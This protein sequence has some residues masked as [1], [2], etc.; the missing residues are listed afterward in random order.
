MSVERL[1]PTPGL[2]AMVIRRAARIPGFENALRSDK[3]DKSVYVNNSRLKAR[4]HEFR[5]VFLR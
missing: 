2:V 4:L 5:V 3:F 1:D